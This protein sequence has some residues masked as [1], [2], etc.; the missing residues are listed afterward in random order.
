MSKLTERIAKIK[1]LRDQGLAYRDIG[2]ALG[3]SDTT[4]R[5]NEQGLKSANDRTLKGSPKCR[6]RLNGNICQRQAGHRG[7]HLSDMT[8]KL[9]YWENK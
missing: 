6:M 7:I 2:Q 4:I 3:Y 9:I 5:A 8:G 1:E